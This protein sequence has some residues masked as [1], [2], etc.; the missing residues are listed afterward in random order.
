MNGAGAL[1]LAAVSYAGGNLLVRS[2]IRQADAFTLTC[3]QMG[4][5]TVVSWPFAAAHA[6]RVRWQAG[7]WLPVA[8]LGVVC[9]GLGWLDNTVLLDA[10]G[11]RGDGT[12]I[13]RYVWPP[14]PLDDP[15]QPV[16]GG[17]C[18]PPRTRIERTTPPGLRAHRRGPRRPQPPVERTQRT[19]HHRP[20]Q[21]LRRPRLPAPL[22]FAGG[23]SRSSSATA[24][25]PA[26]SS[27]R[28]RR[29]ERPHTAHRERASRCPTCGHN[30]M[31]N[32]PD[33][34]VTATA[35]AVPGTDGATSDS[36]GIAQSDRLV[37]INFSG[38]SRTTSN[39]PGKQASRSSRRT[40]RMRCWPWIRAWMTPASRS[41]FW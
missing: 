20:Q 32:N 3:V 36:P 21:V 26:R 13:Y 33:G 30:I 6:A 14:D 1:L 31:L 39:R 27:A 23:T 16:R 28:V 9:S 2:R 11:G 25:L 4:V 15:A 5:A 8:T 10:A 22:A 35:A 12:G 18:T 34:F 29:R 40:V 19:G 37:P 24:G 7:P 41:T 17:T 38:A